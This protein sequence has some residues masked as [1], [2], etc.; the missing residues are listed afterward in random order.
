[1]C[2]FFGF[3]GFTKVDLYEMEFFILDLSLRVPQSRFQSMQDEKT[4]DGC[5]LI[6]HTVANNGLDQIEDHLHILLLSEM[7]WP[8]LVNL[9][10]VSLCQC[11]DMIID[12]SSILDWC[13]GPHLAWNCFYPKKCSYNANVHKQY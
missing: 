8:L 12:V 5:A 10:I 11:I 13:P 1:M 9:S 2:K 4:F 3:Y 7:I 6:Y